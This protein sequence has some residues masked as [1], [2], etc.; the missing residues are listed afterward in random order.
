[1]AFSTKQNHK[2]NV[3]LNS[4]AQPPTLTSSY[5]FSDSGNHLIHDRNNQSTL[6]KRRKNPD[7]TNAQ[8]NRNKPKSQ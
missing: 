4:C 7:I 6:K 1:M 2:S 5:T 8:R 3:L